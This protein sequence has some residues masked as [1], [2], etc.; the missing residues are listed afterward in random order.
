[1]AEA[2]PP[3]VE[4]V[5]RAVEGLHSGDVS[6]L[7]VYAES[8]SFYGPDIPDGIHG[9]DAYENYAKEVVPAFPDL[10]LSVDDVLA[11]DEVVMVEWTWTGTH[12]GEFEGIAPT[13]REVEIR[14]M[15]KA[16]IADGKIQEE[17]GY[18]DLQDFLAQLGITDE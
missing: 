14:G 5:V 3:D 6:N 8:A 4:E 2:S 17:R 9:R 7:D 13:G 11:S 18:Y 12:E 1:M 16:V 15:T 10:R